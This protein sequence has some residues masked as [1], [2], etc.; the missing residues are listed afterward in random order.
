MHWSQP[1]WLPQ[2]TPTVLRVALLILFVAWWLW[3]VNWRN[4]WPA[5][6]EGGWMPLVLVGIMAAYVWSR[7]SPSTVIVLGFMTV[8]N[9]L[10][11]F[12][13]VGLLICLILFC[14]W[15]QTHYGWY[16][17]EVPLEPPP[18]SQDPHASHDA[19]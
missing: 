1:D 16:P 8:P 13:A 2:A 10:W 15:V 19:H 17:P 11:Q 6:A 4:A 12:G 14:G 7:V 9:L 18:P 5:L 3:G